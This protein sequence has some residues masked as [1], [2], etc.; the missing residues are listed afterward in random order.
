MLASFVVAMVVREQYRAWLTVAFSATL[1]YMLF[2]VPGVL[3]L[4]PEDLSAL[5]KIDFVAFWFLPWLAV[6]ALGAGIGLVLR[7]MISPT[8]H[9]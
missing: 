6:S 4:L 5:D 2:L 9:G 1:V 8:P 7:V 3:I